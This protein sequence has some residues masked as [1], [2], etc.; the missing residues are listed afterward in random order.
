MEG[1]VERTAMQSVVGGDGGVREPRAEVVEG[2]LG[3]GEEI[4]PSIRGERDVGGGKDGDEVV[5][6]RADVPFGSEGA[7]V[8]G[9][10]KLVVEVVGCEQLSEGGRRLVVQ[11]DGLDGVPKLPKKN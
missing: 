6:T 3:D 5:F 11:L 8:V 2:E 9:G 7:M 10:G 1:E 4:I